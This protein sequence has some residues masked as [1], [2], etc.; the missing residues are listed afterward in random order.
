MT[1][2]NLLPKKTHNKLLEIPSAKIEALQKDESTS[3]EIS[4]SDRNALG[5]RYVAVKSKSEKLE[6]TQI[7]NTI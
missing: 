4:H 6:L 7:F 5:Q 3:Y 2:T 1:I